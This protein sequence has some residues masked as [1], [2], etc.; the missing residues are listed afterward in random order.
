MMSA[1]RGL[2]SRH[3][4][5]PNLQ[6]TL[7]A[8]SEVF[9]EEGLAASLDRIAERAGVASDPWEGL[10]GFL[11]QLVARLARDRG[12]KEALLLRDRDRASAARDAVHTSVGWLLERA[13]ECGCAR[14]DLAVGDLTLIVLMVTDTADLT[15]DRGPEP[16]AGCFSS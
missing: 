14:V 13:K 16:G 4:G 5:R 8:A 7:A 1:P 9:A 2:R 3:R 12:L 10:L 11:G 6:R 15:R